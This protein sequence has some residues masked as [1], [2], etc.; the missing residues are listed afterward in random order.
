MS[1]V[2]DLG[3]RDAPAGRSGE[4]PPN[5][6]QL[7]RGPRAGRLTRVSFEAVSLRLAGVTRTVVRLKTGNAALSAISPNTTREVHSPLSRRS[8]TSS[9]G[10]P[11]FTPDDIRVIATAHGHGTKAA[12]VGDLGS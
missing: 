9:T 5:W 4:V 6:L 12:S 10:T 1:S 7:V 2:A 8:K 3:E 11:C